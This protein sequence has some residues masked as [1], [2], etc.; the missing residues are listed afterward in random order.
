M[1]NIEFGYLGYY[2]SDLKDIPFERYYVGGDGLQQSQ[3]DG[4]EVVGLRGYENSSLSASNGGT[5]FNKF[6]MEVR[7]P[8]TLKTICVYLCFRF[9]RIRK[10]VSGFS[11][12]QSIRC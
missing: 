7:Y 1:T 8:I 4:R 5:I 3:F 2:N 12:I 11:I 9:C 6:S 10:L